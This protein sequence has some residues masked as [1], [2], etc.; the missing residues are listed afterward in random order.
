[1][2]TLFTYLLI[3]FGNVASRFEAIFYDGRA[4]QIKGML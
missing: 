3:L 2:W 1:M 4:K